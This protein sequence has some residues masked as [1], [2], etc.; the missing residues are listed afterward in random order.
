VPYLALLPFWGKVIAGGP[1]IP[2]TD[3]INLWVGQTRLVSLFKE[4]RMLNVLTVTWASVTAI[5]VGVAD[6]RA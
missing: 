2:V 3:R 4:V 5:L 6:Y 1:C